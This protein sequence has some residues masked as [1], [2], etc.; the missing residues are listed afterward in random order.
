VVFYQE[1]IYTAAGNGTFGGGNELTS[2][3]SL[4]FGGAVQ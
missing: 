3:E 4:K 1:Q 2:L